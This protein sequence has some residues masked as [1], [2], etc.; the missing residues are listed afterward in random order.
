MLFLAK[1]RNKICVFIKEKATHWIHNSAFFSQSA[2]PCF[3]RKKK[4]KKKCTLIPAKIK[5]LFTL[6]PVRHLV[7]V[8]VEL[9]G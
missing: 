8:H 7:H 6:S 4:L 2:G 3:A 1:E 5:T 9:R